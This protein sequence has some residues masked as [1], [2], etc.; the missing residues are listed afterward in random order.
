MQG[1]VR[2]RNALNCIE[3]HLGDYNYSQV[4]PLTSIA[5]GKTADYKIEADSPGGR[6]RAQAQRV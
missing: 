4:E 2:L 3:L 5:A 1:C 6:P